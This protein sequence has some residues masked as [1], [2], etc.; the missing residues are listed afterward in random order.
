MGW[1]ETLQVNQAVLRVPI[2]RYAHETNMNRDH[3]NRKTYCICSF[4][5]SALNKPYSF[6]YTTLSSRIVPEIQ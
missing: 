5:Q 1:K 4:A 6:G 3:N 2:L